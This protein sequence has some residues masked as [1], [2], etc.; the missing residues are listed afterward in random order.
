M[1]GAK[2]QTTYTL[3][4]GKGILAVEYKLINLD[5]PTIIFL[6]DSLGCITLWRDFPERLSNALQC[7]YFIYDRWGYGNASLNESLRQR[8]NDYLAK[9]ADILIELIQAFLIKQ[10][11]LFGHSDGGS[12]ALIA[13]AKSPSLIAGLISQAGHIF[14]EAITLKGIK[15]TV[16]RYLTTDFRDKLIKYHGSKVDDVF[17]GWTDIW[18]SDDFKDW[19]IR[20]LLSKITSPLLLIQ[21]EKD[22][23][24]TLKQVNIP[25]K[26]VSGHSKSLII[27]NVGHA[28]HKE[29]PDLVIKEINKFVNRNF[30]P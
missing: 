11:I 9:E 7:N 2:K 24:G 13:A 21:G 30:K 10:P 5:A 29:N 15:A 8:D 26:L 27:P 4:T 25:L 3:K 22:E 19:D 28:P 18:L 17:Y 23:Y 6:H 20:S 1:K 14:V 12:I 16:K